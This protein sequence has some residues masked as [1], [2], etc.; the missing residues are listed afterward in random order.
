MEYA[1]KAD[2]IGNS[3]MSEANT[4]KPQYDYGSDCNRKSGDNSDGDIARDDGSDAADDSRCNAEVTNTHV[5]TA[6]HED[7]ADGGYDEYDDRDC[8]ADGDLKSDDEDKGNDDKKKDDGCD[9]YDGRDCV[10]GDRSSDGEEISD[11]DTKGRDECDE[12]HNGDGNS[13]HK[14][15]CGD[16]GSTHSGIS[17]HES[18]RHNIDQF[19]H[20]AKEMQKIKCEITRK[21]EKNIK[22]AQE[23]DKFYY[24][25]KHSNMKVCTAYYTVAYLYN[26][27]PI[28][29]VGIW[30]RGS[31][32]S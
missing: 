12:Y 5:G 28:T 11:S 13:S 16:N 19:D 8:F 27:L 18:I 21:V 9:E 31:C 15:S 20:Y 1:L 25:K 3:T 2:D 14:S 4:S 32:T 29:S 30:S 10:N 24:D 7:K 17:N 23:K 26:A 22:K 6:I